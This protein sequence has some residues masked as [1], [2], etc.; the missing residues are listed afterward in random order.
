MSSFFIALLFFA[1][2]QGFTRVSYSIYCSSHFGGK[3]DT[4]QVVSQFP[5]FSVGMDRAS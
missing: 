5:E 1:K 2:D 4:A 3:L